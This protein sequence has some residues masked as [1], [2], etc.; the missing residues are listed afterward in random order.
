MAKV[1]T[2]HGGRIHL[3][4]GVKSCGSNKGGKGIITEDGEEL[5]ADEV[6][7]NGDF[8]HVMSHLVDDGVLR[9]YSKEKLKKKK[10]S[11][12]TFMIYL[13]ID[14]QYDIPHHSIV[15]AEDYKQNVEEITKPIAFRKTH[16]SIYR[17][18]R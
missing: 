10:Y 8:A 9:K 5:E 3:G 4:R 1:V 6:I 11:C 13:G 18:L 2:E 17:M 15:F 16:P 14:K 7:I 12:S